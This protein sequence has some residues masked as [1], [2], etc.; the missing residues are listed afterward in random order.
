MSQ[1][2]VPLAL[3]LLRGNPGKRKLPQHEPTPD[4]LASDTAVPEALLD[5]PVAA[6]EWTRL[7]AILADTRVMTEA[8]RAGLLALC[9]QWS[10]YLQSSASV[11]KSPLQKHPKTGLFSVSPMVGL[12]QKALNACHRL[13]IEFGLTPVSRTKVTAA[14]KDANAD[15]FAEF[16]TLNRS[17]RGA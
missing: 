8:D 3:K 2:P 12:S 11:R 4:V 1:R 15:A 10:L 6:K 16:E 14:P 7:V 17:T 9:Q 5:D 13:W